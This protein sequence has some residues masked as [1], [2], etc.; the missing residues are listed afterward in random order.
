MT[1]IRKRLATTTLILILIGIS[2]LVAWNRGMLI[3]TKPRSR[4]KLDIQSSA[5]ALK[6]DFAKMGWNRFRGPNGTGQSN[7]SLIPS[8]WDETHNLLWKTELPGKGSSSPVLSSEKVFLTTYIADNNDDGIIKS[9]QRFLCCIDQESGKI[10]WSKS[11]ETILPE[12]ANRGV[13]IP[14]HGY[15]TNSC[16]V[17]E[18]FV[19]SFYGKSGVYCHDHVGNEVWR[20]S[21]GT[22]LNQN[23]WGSCSSLILFNDIL[24]V[25]AAEECGSLLGIEKSTG[26][27]VW[28]AGE[29]LSFSFSTPALVPVDSERT[30]LVIAVVGELWGLNPTNGKLVW[31]AKSPIAGNVSPCINVDGDLVYSYGGFDQRGSI[32]VQAGGS[33]D[34]TESHMRWKSETTSYVASP[35]IHE[36]KIYWVGDS[37][38][39][40]CVDALTGEQ[41]EKARMPRSVGNSRPVYASAIAIDGRIFVQTRKKGVFVLGVGGP[42]KILSHNIF[43]SDNSMFN[44]TPAVGAGQLFLRS[45]QFLYCIGKK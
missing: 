16:V 7:D 21:V 17:D 26:K 43:E 38:K 36:K 30:D 41:V 35:V 4:P 13:G 32:C 23:N 15:A 25:N 24:I 27:E 42:L 6:M 20:I 9:L 10:D 34:V 29:K 33:G 14:E 1:L 3:R 40:H 19:Y 11:I 22:G 37:G 8:E 28:R 45:D 2:V 12:S 18:K 31:F 39:Y 5:S 44:A